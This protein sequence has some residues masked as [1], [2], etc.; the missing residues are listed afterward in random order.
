[1]RFL[2]VVAFVV[3]Q[4]ALVRLSQAQTLLIQD[5]FENSYSADWTDGETWF[6][7]ANYTPNTSAQRYVTTPTPPAG[8]YAAHY[9]V[10]GGTFGNEQSPFSFCKYADGED[11]WDELHVTWYYY[12]SSSYCWTAS[13]KMFRAGHYLGT[14]GRNSVRGFLR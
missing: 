12:F 13:Q 8:S 2:L 1:M 3:L 11:T 5:S 9:F 7:A 4:S 14:I 6:D 10:K